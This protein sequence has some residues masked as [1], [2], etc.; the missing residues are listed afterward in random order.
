MRR[1]TEF[2]LAQIIALDKIGGYVLMNRHVNA[3]A[4]HLSLRPPQR[5]SL[6]ILDRITVI[7]P[8]R[9]NIDLADALAAIRSEFP[10][11]TSAGIQGPQRNE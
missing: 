9:K 8:L 2:L 11:V 4:G 7:A 6:E 5:H 3:I 10:T 1:A